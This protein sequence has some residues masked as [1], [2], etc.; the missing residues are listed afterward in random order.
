MSDR[1]VLDLLAISIS[2]TQSVFAAQL[3]YG[4]CIVF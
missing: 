3:N 1:R 4:L 2:D